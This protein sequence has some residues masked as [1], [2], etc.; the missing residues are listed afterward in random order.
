[1]EWKRE[2]R[3]CR[4]GVTRSG[5]VAAVALLCLAVPAADAGVLDRTLARL[6][7]VA[8]LYRDN[9]LGF[10]CEEDIAYSGSERGH[11]RFAYLFIRDDHGKLRDF[12]TWKSGAKGDEVDPR[13]YH[14][15]RYLES[16]YLW[17]FVFRSDR[18]PLYRFAL[19]DDET[20][21]DPK[22][23]VIRF[24]PRAPVRK[25]VND[26]AGYARIDRGTSQILS[27]EAYT[28]ED[29]NRM[30]MR[31]ADAAMAG[32]RDPHEDA[33]TYDVER[34]VTEFGFDKNGMRFPSH[35]EIVKTRSTVVP[36]ATHDA[37]K[38]TTVRRVTQ[39]YTKFEFF[40]VRSSE[41][42]TRFVNGDAAL[43]SSPD[44]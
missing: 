10:A 18:Q 22:A 38:T 4:L 28:P 20:A 37:V 3:D 8:E 41:E 17:A 26:W 43:A 19:R 6:A 40:S 1:M 36:G 42:I 13:D 21:G 2:P 23:V 15:P 11:V 35:V 29:W 33:A 30:L 39:D 9:A 24:V 27:V 31:D 14:V 34:I 12:R 44:R 16:A 7:R 25:G 5:L 32:K